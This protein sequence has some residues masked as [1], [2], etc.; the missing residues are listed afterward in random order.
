M[1][2]RSHVIFPTLVRRKAH[3]NQ[4]KL[5]GKY[6]RTCNLIAA[7]VTFIEVADLSK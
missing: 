1:Y 4:T 3:Y 2:L 5:N 6:K 7:F